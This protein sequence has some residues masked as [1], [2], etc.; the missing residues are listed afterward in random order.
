MT[1]RRCHSS[2][3]DSSQTLSKEWGPDEYGKTIRITFSFVIGICVCMGLGMR[4]GHKV[5]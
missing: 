2:K 3:R 5:V 1:G 4:G